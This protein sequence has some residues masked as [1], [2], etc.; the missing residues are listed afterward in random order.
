MHYIDIKLP[1]TVIEKLFPCTE[2]EGTGVRPNLRAVAIAYGVLGESKGMEWHTPDVFSV[3][4][5]SSYVATATVG[6]TSL[7]F[8]SS[9]G[10]F[11]EGDD[12]KL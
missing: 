2:P 12:R 6:D 5:G 7:R 3:R 11:R 8:H 9:E 10:D 4:Y 1:N